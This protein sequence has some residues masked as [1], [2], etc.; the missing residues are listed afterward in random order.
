MENV[1]VT[2]VRYRM[3]LPVIRSLGRAGARV[4]CTDLAK[5]PERA[6][7]GFASKYAHACARLPDPEDAEA[8]FSALA[9]LAQDTRPAVLPV[10]ID[11]L[12]ALCSYPAEA[13]SAFRTA[14]PPLPS[15][16]LANDKFAL[17]RQAE[18]VGV[19]CPAT[20]TLSAGEDVDALAA[21][22]PYP[23]VVKY[24]AGELLRLDPK[25][26][27]RIVATPEELA[28]AFSSMHARQ[29][30]PL[31]QE[32]V[33]G[34]GFG[35]SAVFDKEH[36]PLQVF[37]HRRL[38]EY[39]V[40][41]GPSCLCES[42][43]DEELVRHAVALLRSLGWVGV[44]MVE[45]KG[46]P[47]AGYKLMEINPRFWGSLALAPAAGCDIPLALYRAACG[48][49]AGSAD[50]SPDYRL[51]KRMRFFLQDAL[52]LKGYLKRAPDKLPFALKYIGSL[53]DPRIADGVFSMGDPKPG[54][55]YLRQALHKTDKIIR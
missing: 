47:A 55:R 36:N 49:L 8:F 32:Y 25:D 21:R 34:E 9:A 23:A 46:G 53:L 27:Y 19:P 4:I 5:T 11:T 6:A 13:E 37:C 24:R 3:S 50:P 38:R 33:P 43:W 52:A 29:P 14:L 30:Y 7:L 28:R 12:L 10:G 1:I 42:A 35:V 39:P 40:T 48:E 16:Q 2:D 41:G 54:L 26:R 15:I 51:G 45:F 44:A 22:V 31:V 18:A 20:T 17:V